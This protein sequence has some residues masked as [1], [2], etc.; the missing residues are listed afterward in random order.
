MTVDTQIDSHVEPE[1]RA[2]GNF[3]R[4]CAA[5][6]MSPLVITPVGMFMGFGA[7]AHDSG[8][9]LVWTA[10]ASM[11]MFAVPGQILLVTGISQDAAM[12]VVAVA[13]TFS[14]V[15]YAPMVATLLPLIRFPG[16]RVQHVLF[17]V[18]CIVVSLW[19]EALRLIP[20]LQRERRVAFCNGL[21]AT[22]FATGMI[23]TVAGYYLAG[24]M[25]PLFAAALLFVTPISFLVITAGS[26]R[27]I[28]DKLALILGLGLSAGAW[29]LE[30]TFDMLWVGV[31]AGTVAY[32][33]QLTQRRWAWAI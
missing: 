5:M 11:L 31:I 32:G 30:I 6:S 10:L 15:R 8:F 2:L 7:L 1:C 16:V 22:F 21:A 18:H 12:L 19:L 26:S 4:G 20:N 27:T 13:V 17:P 9:S 24:A 23:A 33:V 14:A 28:V 25:P 29:L 3:L